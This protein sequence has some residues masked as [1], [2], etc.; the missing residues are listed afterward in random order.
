LGGN[1]TGNANES[2]DGYI[3]QVRIFNKAL[4]A[5]EAATLYS[6]GG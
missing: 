1:F 4:D 5:S 3:D 6:R 2:F